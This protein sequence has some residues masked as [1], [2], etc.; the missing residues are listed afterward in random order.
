MQMRIMQ[1][2]QKNRLGRSRRALLLASSVLILSAA[3][4]AQPHSATAASSTEETFS[5]VCQLLGK[6]Y[7]RSIQSY[8]QEFGPVIS[9]YVKEHR[10]SF[11][12]KTVTARLAQ[13][14]EL[15]YFVTTNPSRTVLTGIK[16]EGHEV[17]HK[18]SVDVRSIRDVQQWL[19]LPDYLKED[20][21][22]DPFFPHLPHEQ[23]GENPIGYFCD[24]LPG[25][26]KVDPPNTSS[27]GIDP[28]KQTITISFHWAYN[29]F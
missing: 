22:Q 21:P 29:Y 27:I 24:R 19:G 1:Q 7:Q 18:L 17:L 12:W 4:Y 20:K 5:P 28:I 16:A 6:L 23:L 10:S 3:L 14:V 11:L 13:H 25:D 9:S 26:E 2:R 8:E 15:Y